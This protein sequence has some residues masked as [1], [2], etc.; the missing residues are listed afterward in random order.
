MIEA[1]ALT[2]VFLSAVLQCTQRGSSAQNRQLAATI[3]TWRLPKAW[4]SLAE[5]DRHSVQAALLN[6]YGTC[7]EWAVLRVLAE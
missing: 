6:C 5:S 7:S 2:P 3:L 1:V 4:P